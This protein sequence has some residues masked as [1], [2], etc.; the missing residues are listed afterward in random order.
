MQEEKI[1]FRNP[2]MLITFSR[3]VSAVIT[4]FFLFT[5]FFTFF[6]ALV[7]G[8]KIWEAISDLIDGILAKQFGFATSLGRRLDP[9]AD[10]M[11]NIP[12]LVFIG[13]GN[14][15]LLNYLSGPF[16]EINPIALW[17]LFGTEAIL[18]T[19]GHLLEKRYGYEVRPNYAG[20]CKM[21]CECVFIA[22]YFWTYLK[23]FAMISGPNWILFITA[24]ALLLTTSLAIGSLIWHAMDILWPA[25]KVSCA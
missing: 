6:P 9:L 3:M 1:D 22:L 8:M 4:C 15:G 10:K 25:R 2:A 12:P 17:L 16:P 18:L 11:S 14:L 21:A 20:K 7:F 19:F 5:G 13:L 23:P 24:K